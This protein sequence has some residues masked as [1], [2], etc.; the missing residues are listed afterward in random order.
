MNCHLQLFWWNKFKPIF[1][2]SVKIVWKWSEYIKIDLN[3]HF[4]LF[5]MKNIISC[6]KNNLLKSQFPFRFSSYCSFVFSIALSMSRSIFSMLL[7]VSA[8]CVWVVTSQRMSAVWIFSPVSPNFRFYKI[9]FISVIFHYFSNLFF[10]TAFLT[11][12]CILSMAVKFFATTRSEDT[13]KRIPVFGPKL[14]DLR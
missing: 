8:M 10:W 2:K 12:L 11:H 7:N 13:Y 4:N 1:F 6:D 5:L 9:A 14:M 3:C